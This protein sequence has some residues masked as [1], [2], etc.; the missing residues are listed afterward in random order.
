M[1]GGFIGLFLA[2]MQCTSV[3]SSRQDYES[4]IGN[5]VEHKIKIESIHE[6]PANLPSGTTRKVDMCMVYL[7]QDKYGYTG[8]HATRAIAWLPHHRTSFSQ[9]RSEAHSPH[10]PPQYTLPSTRRPRTITTRPSTYRAYRAPDSTT[11]Y[12]SPRQ[13]LLPYDQHSVLYQW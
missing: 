12:T 8:P 5:W 1:L 11:Q 3:S 13:V 10:I 6:T 7:V 9:N 2:N 4:S